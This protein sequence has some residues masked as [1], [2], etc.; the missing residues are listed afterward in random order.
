MIYTKLMNAHFFET[1]ASL[2]LLV[3]R[4]W[5]GEKERRESV[6]VAAAMFVLAVLYE[7]AS[8][9]LAPSY[10]FNIFEFVGTWTGL[11]C[12]W[13]SR[14][15]NILCWPWGI[16][17]SLALGVFFAQINLP[18]QEWLNAGYFTVVQLWAWPYWA[19]GGHTQ[20]ELPVSG[21]S[22]RGWCA[23]IVSVIVGTAVV[24][25]MIG[26][27]APGSLYP[28]FD[29]LVV[30]ASVTAQFLLGKKKVESWY[31]W[32]GPVNLVSMGLFFA[33]GAYTLTALYV[34]YFVHALFAV[35]S[36]RRVLAVEAAGRN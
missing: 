26:V 9:Q 15:R 30:A 16:A 8:R 7:L 12:V 19:F 17:S 25:E 35:L 2:R 5:G 3:R 22:V 31:L 18:G 14:T 23:T 32:L 36:W 10:A 4:L 13:L 28:F 27:F 33:A 20:T 11:V 21:L 1:I 29:S 34:A 24:Y 6:A